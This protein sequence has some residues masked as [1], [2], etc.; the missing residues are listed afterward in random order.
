MGRIGRQPVLERDRFLRRK[1][2]IV[3]GFEPRNGRR[4]GLLRRLFVVFSFRHSDTR[5]SRAFHSFSLSIAA[6][7]A[8]RAAFIC[9]LISAWLQPVAA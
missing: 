7:I 3:H 1:R 4:P 9:R 6:C 5:K 2:A 8:L